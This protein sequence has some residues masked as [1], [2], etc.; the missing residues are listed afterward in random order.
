MKLFSSLYFQSV[1]NEKADW[2]IVLQVDHVIYTDG[3]HVFYT[4]ATLRSAL[5]CGILY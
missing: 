4:F 3:A 5:E 2:I 1:I